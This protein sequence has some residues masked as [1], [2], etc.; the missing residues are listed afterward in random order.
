MRLLPP[1]LQF[2]YFKPTIKPCCCQLVLFIYLT[3]PFCSGFMTW[4]KLVPAQVI[5]LI[6]LTVIFPFL[7]P[8]IFSS[9][10]LCNHL[11]KAY[12]LY[13]FVFFSYSHDFMFFFTTVV[14]FFFTLASERFAIG[15]DLPYGSA[16]LKYFLTDLLIWVFIFQ[17]YLSVHSWI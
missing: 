6:Q 1:R 8:A 12:L 11:L 15:S 4:R 3:F 10:S 7:N 17:V 14:C 5:L 9:L 16:V 13:H 2:F